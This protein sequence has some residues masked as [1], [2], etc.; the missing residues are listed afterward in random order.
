MVNLI[1]TVPAIND[2]LKIPG[3][4]LH[5]YDKAPRPGRKLGHVTIVDADRGRLEEKLSAVQQIVGLL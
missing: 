4:H 2:I 3:A 1:G 5:L